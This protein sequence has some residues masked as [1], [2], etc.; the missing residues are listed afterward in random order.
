MLRLCSRLSA[1]MMIA[2]VAPAFAQLTPSAAVTPDII[3]EGQ[4]VTLIRDGFAAA[5]IA[6][7]ENVIWQPNGQ[8]VVL[9]NAGLGSMP[10]T[11]TGGPGTYWY[12]FRLVDNNIAYQDQ[13]ISFKVTGSLIAQA[14]VSTNSMAFGIGNNIILYQNGSATAGIAWTENVI[15]RPDGKPQNLG[16]SGLGQKYYWP[17]MQGTYWYQ[18]RL[19]D[20]NGSYT[21][22]WISFE[23]TNGPEVVSEGR[24]HVDS[25]NNTWYLTSNYGNFLSYHG[26]NQQSGVFDWDHMYYRSTSESPYLE[27]WLFERVPNI[28]HTTGTRWSG[29]ASILPGYT[30]TT[31]PQGTRHGYYETFLYAP[32]SGQFYLQW[33]A[34]LANTTP[35]TPPPGGNDPGPGSDL[36]R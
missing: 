2:F 5:G 12:Q 3:A 1:I 20:N 16:N 22:Q 21:D 18:F 36:P 34:S 17:P 26:Y 9:G 4:S 29:P 13:W 31:D 7:T 10:Y 8:A 23:V 28:G 24:W 35:S 6:W 14:S 32:G 33:D 19:V 15:W 27:Y 11:P 25:N 30:V